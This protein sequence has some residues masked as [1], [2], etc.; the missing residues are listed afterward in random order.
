MRAVRARGPAGPIVSEQI[1][2][3]RPAPGEVL[4]AV[5]AAA[6]TAGELAW[7]QTWPAIPGHEISGVAAGL[8]VGVTGLA[9]GQRVYGLIGF[10]RD[11][12]AAEYVTAPAADLA[13]KPTSVDH[14]GAASLAL[15]AL[16]A[17]QAL[18]RHARLAAGQHVLV[19]GGAGGVGSYAIQVAAALGAR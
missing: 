1:P 8:G 18:V 13:V 9:V 2:A 16:T 3:P 7:P 10:D 14:V 15:A 4:V 12:G 5:H 17:W 19:N 11:G 6:L